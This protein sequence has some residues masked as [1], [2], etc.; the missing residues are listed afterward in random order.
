MRTRFRVISLILLLFSPA[1]DLMRSLDWWSWGE[2]NP[3]P[4]AIAGQFY[5]RSRLI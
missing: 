3:R 1:S 4:Q 5:M 2:S